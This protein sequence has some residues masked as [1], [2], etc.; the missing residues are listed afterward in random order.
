[1]NMDPNQHLVDPLAAEWEKQW[2]M[3][4]HLTLFVLPV[5]WIPVIP[6]LIMW[7]I[8]RKESP[9]VDDQG[10]E[11]VNFHLTLLVYG[12]VVFFLKF[13]CVGYLLWYVLA[14]F[15]YVFAVLGAVAAGRGQFYRYPMCLRMI[16]G[17]GKKY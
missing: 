8:K 7:M 3:F 2:A 5:A 13:I 11:V 1:M 15:G 12:V 10:R 17:G 9:F 6:A 4:T 16:G 14:G